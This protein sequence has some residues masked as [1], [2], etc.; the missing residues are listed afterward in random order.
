MPE[1]ALLPQNVQTDV[2]LGGGG[3]VVMVCICGGRNDGGRG[4]L[5]TVMGTISRP[6]M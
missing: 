2:R 6:R 1:T 3:D 5:Y 4:G